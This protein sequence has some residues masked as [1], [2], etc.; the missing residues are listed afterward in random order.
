MM[1]IEIAYRSH[2]TGLWITTK[3]SLLSVVPKTVENYNADMYG[4][5]IDNQLTFKNFSLDKV[6]TVARRVVHTA[7]LL[8]LSLIA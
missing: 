8:E 4:L 6:Q 3:E 1:K 7:K 5:L 2:H